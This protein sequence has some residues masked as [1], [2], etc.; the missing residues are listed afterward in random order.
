[1]SVMISG[2]MVSFAP[3]PK[4]LTKRDAKKDAYDGDAAIQMSEIK[5]MK[6]QTIM[7]GLLP[8]ICAHG[9]MM[10]LV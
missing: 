7:V 6:Q 4:P 10:K 9:M 1:M 3:V 2:I 5:V 8:K